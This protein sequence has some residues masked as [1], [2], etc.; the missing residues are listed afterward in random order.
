[1][2]GRDRD[3]LPRQGR[4]HR[5]R[6]VPR[7]WL[8]DTTG[9]G[10]AVDRATQGPAYGRREEDQQGR[11]SGRAGHPDL[12]GPYQVR[13][14]VIEGVEGRCLWAGRRRR[15]RR[16]T[17]SQDEQFKELKLDDV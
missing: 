15:G 16:V 1:M 3:G 7:S 17:M 14:A 13:A 11:R 5:G 4:G 9:I 10:V 8:R 12:A 2:R 6:E